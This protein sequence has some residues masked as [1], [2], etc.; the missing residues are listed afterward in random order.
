MKY[1]KSYSTKLN[2]FVE[3]KIFENSFFRHRRLVI[4]H[5]KKYL[6]DDASDTEGIIYFYEILNITNDM[7]N[8][9]TINSYN[10][11]LDIFI[12]NNDTLNMR[13]T[14]FIR[15]SNIVHQT[16]SYEDAN[17]MFFI[18]IDAKKYNL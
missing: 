17:E 2:S 12:R 16:D 8:L 14:R 18:Y 9:K 7:I 3:S 15:I 13:I 11:K 5:L 4:T 1:L 6:I 10:N